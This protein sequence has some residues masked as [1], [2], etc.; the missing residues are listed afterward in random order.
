MGLEMGST[1]PDGDGGQLSTVTDLVNQNGRT[2]TEK[3]ITSSRS[4]GTSFI[5]R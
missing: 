3:T 5:I 4:V 2:I 1:S